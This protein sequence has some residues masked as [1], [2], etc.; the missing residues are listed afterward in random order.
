MAK[1]HPMPSVTIPDSPTPTRRLGGS[2]RAAWFIV[3]TMMLAATA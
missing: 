1:P 3:L 2:V